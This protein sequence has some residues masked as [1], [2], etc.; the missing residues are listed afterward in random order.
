MN[1]EA[2][3]N[4]IKMF[5]KKIWLSEDNRNLLNLVKEWRIKLAPATIYVLDQ[6]GFN[7][8]EI[9]SLAECAGKVIHKLPT[10]DV[11]F[12]NLIQRG[13]ICVQLPF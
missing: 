11:D 3:N 6:D 2:L 4:D 10:G 5:N 7:Y 8:L 12:L 9:I 13:S 1:I